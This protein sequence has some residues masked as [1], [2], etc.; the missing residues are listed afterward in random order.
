MIRI[1]LTIGLLQAVVL[2][3][4]HHDVMYNVAKRT[5]LPGGGIIL[6]LILWVIW[7]MLV[8]PFVLVKALIYDEN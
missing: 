1:Y 4:W 7:M 2:V 6:A 3:Y 5:K 8:W